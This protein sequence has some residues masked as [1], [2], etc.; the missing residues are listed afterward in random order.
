VIVMKF[1]GTSVADAAAIERLMSIVRAARQAAI[2]PES[3]DWRGPIVIASA[4]GGA[5]D[6][7]LGIAAEAGAGDLEGARNNL[8]ALCNRHLEVASVI[9]DAAERAEVEKY[10]RKE[11]A[12]LERIVGALAVLR[13][14]TPRWLD[15]IAAQGELLSSRIVAAALSS[16]GLAATWVDARQ[17]MVTTDEHTSAAPLE[18][19]TIAALT[20]RVDPLLAAR[21]I[22][23][24]GGFVGATRD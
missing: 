2:Q 22:P 24:V 9:V 17:V 10:I 21:R 5:T 19:E 15:A 18:S 1:G 7:L 13:E 11:L 3:Q 6:R 14:V 16:H 8:L 20:S 12:G 4:L 23:V